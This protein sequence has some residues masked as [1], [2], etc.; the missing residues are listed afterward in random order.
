VTVG[1]QPPVWVR[2]AQGEEDTQ[3]IAAEFAAAV[4]RGLPHALRVYLTGDLGAGKTTFVRGFLRRLGVAGP[5]RSPTYSL[6]EQYEPPGHRVLHVDLY[7]LAEPEDVA[8][9]GFGDFDLPGA[10]WLIEWPERAGGELPPPDLTLRLTAGTVEHWVEASPGS[11]AGE[12]WLAR[13]QQA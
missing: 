6:L 4:P 5:V 1:P 3:A 10:V 11:A 2:R 12:G 13:L 9:L 8:A 7:R